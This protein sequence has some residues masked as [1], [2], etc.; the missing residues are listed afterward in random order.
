MV[1]NTHSEIDITPVSTYFETIYSRIEIEDKQ[2]QQNF[3]IRKKKNFA[4]QTYRHTNHGKLKET[5]QIE[6]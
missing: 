6:D 3:T 5:L 4:K 2:Q 1:H